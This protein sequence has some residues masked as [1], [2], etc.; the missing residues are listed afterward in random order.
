MSVFPSFSCL[1]LVA[2]ALLPLGAQAAGTARC[3]GLKS[4]NYAILNPVAIDL[5]SRAVVV[6]FDASTLTF[7]SGDALTPSTDTCAFT[8][9]DGGSL[10]ASK[11]GVF[12]A[13]PKSNN[14]NLVVGFRPVTMTLRQIAGAWNFI[15]QSVDGGKLHTHN[16]V[17]DIAR[18]GDVKVTACDANGANCAATGQV[19]KLVVNPLGGFDLTNSTG[20]IA[21]IFASKAADRTKL[22]ASVSVEPAGRS[23]FFAS[24]VVTNTLPTVGAQWSIWDFTNASNGVASGPAISSFT[25]TSVDPANSSFTR[26]RAEDCRIDSFKINSGRTGMSFRP[27]GSFTKCT[28]G[29][30]NFGNFLTLPLRESFGFTPYGYE[31]ATNSFLGI[32]IQ[33]P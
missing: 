33:R 17:I 11:S 10:Y 32:S 12:A 21:R 1:S 15:E 25:V 19:P 3:A 30:A 26:I 2:A 29:T 16:G 23:F 9:F 24:P 7:S 22:L 28:G 5:G 18:N 6:G 13:L 27:A 20:V 4:G 8:L 14:S 31:S